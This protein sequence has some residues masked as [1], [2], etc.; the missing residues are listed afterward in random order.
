LN[1]TDYFPEYSEVGYTKKTYGVQG[2]I[3]VHINEEFVPSFDKAEHV[4]FLMKGCLVPYFIETNSDGLTKFESCKNPEDAREIVAKSIYMHQ[5]QIE[6]V[7]KTHDADSFT[8]VEGFKL[9]DAETEEL[10]GIID[11]VVT[12]PQQEIASVG[13]IMIPLNFEN[14]KGID[15]ESKAVYV[16][17][18]EGL[19][20]I[21]R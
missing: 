11:E 14:V 4:F 12:Y 17:I 13:D 9:Y 2:Q 19:L 7:E 21:N 18:P 5:G 1:I 10:V 6:R 20:D 16:D 15:M 8:V 3:R